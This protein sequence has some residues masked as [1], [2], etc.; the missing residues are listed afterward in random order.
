MSA[1]AVADGA[2]VQ[3]GTGDAGLHLQVVVDGVDCSKAASKD[4]NSEAKAGEVKDGGA[5]H[6]C[7]A[8][9][10]TRAPGEGLWGGYSPRQT[11]REYL[12]TSSGSPSRA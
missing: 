12:K 5:Q 1:V 8:G 7:W 9:Q 6:G 3:L 11:A 10:K 2:V 4:A